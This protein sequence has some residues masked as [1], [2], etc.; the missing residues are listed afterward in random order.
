MY[1]AGASIKEIQ[2]GEI[3]H[4]M[5]LWRELTKMSREVSQ[6]I[7]KRAFREPFINLK[8]LQMINIVRDQKAKPLDFLLIK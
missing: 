6:A 3:R 4:R 1:R 2:V 5:K 7:L 8:S